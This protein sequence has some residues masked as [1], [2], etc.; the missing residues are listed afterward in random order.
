DESWFKLNV[1]LLRKALDITHKNSKN[2]FV[3]PPAAVENHS[4]Y[5]QPML[6]W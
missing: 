1:K 2:P 4:H 5:A 6:D 3:P